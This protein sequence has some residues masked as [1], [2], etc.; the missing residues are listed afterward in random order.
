[1]SAGKVKKVSKPLCPRDWSALR[2]RQQLLG[3]HPLSKF[4]QDSHY[5]IKPSNAVAIAYEIDSRRLRRRSADRT[6]GR[7]E[8]LNRNL[9]EAL[10]YDEFARTWPQEMG[11]RALS[12]STWN[13]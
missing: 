2:G 1:M 7:F 9:P 11:R 10:A 4:Q 3:I 6:A 5:L 8:A 13:S 12:R